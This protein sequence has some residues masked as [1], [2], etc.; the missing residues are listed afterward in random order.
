MSLYKVI[1]LLPST[2]PLEDLAVGV[3]EL[4]APYEI[5]NAWSD[6]DPPPPPDGVCRCGYVRARSTARAIVDELCSEP[7]GGGEPYTAMLRRMFD[8]LHLYER[9]FAIQRRY[10]L[11]SP[12]CRICGGTGRYPDGLHPCGKFDGVVYG[13]IHVDGW[14][15]GEPQARDWSTDTCL[16]DN[17]TTVPELLARSAKG[18]SIVTYALV[19]PDGFWHE[20]PWEWDFACDRE[21]RAHEE[22]FL[23]RLEQHRDCWAVGVECHT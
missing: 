18:D 3:D 23:A 13:G 15:T 12:D 5:V 1:V 11:H 8:S 9:V 4:L 14:I 19:T 22:K 7:K 21:R 6:H 20:V 16:E 17:L 10:E 2:T